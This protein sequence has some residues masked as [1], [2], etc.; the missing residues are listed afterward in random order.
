MSTVNADIQ[1]RPIYIGNKIAYAVHL[2]GTRQVGLK[3]GYVI[4]RK[5]DGAIVVEVDS[6]KWVAGLGHQ[7]CKRIVTLRHPDRIVVL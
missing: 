2:G 3:Q 7:P 5:D 1:G 4:D 6:T